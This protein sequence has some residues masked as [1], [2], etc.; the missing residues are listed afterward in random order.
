VDIIANDQSL[1]AFSSAVN[2]AKFANAVFRNTFMNLTVFAPAVTPEEMFYDVNSHF[3]RGSRFLTDSSWIVHLRD[4][5]NL[6]VFTEGGILSNQL[7]NTNDLAMRNGEQVQITHLA[8][9][10]TMLSIPETEQA[11]MLESNIWASNGI[12]H[13]IDATLLPI[14]YDHDLFNL[15]ITLRVLWDDVNV[16]M[17]LIF[18]AVKNGLQIFGMAI[19]V[20][21]PFDSAWLEIE[22]EIL[23]FY[24][25]PANVLPLQELL[26]GHIATTVY[27]Y[28]GVND[29]NVLTTLAGT[30]LLVSVLPNS[31][32]MFNDVTLDSRKDLLASDGLVHG[33][34]KVLLPPPK[35]P[36]IAP[37]SSPPNTMDSASDPPSGAPKVS[38]TPI[39]SKN[40][41]SDDRLSRGAIAGLSVGAVLILVTM[42]ACTFYAAHQWELKNRESPLAFS[43]GFIQAVVVPAAEC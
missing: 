27:P 14:W 18:E 36:T 35:Q 2:A 1:A 19:M 41:Q 21:F 37:S 15:A 31:T 32:V 3:L 38:Q 9:G 26:Q 11:L 20:F 4:I 10:S 13:K 39:D 24:R 43:A 29:G 23:A 28:V 34:D 12:V 30:Q 8:A 5:I 17:E 6:H 16:R 40:N 25:D 22:P 33:I 42:A 7:N